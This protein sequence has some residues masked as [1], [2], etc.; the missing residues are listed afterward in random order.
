MASIYPQS[1]GDWV[2]F[3][4]VAG[5][6]GAWL[7]TAVS[8]ALVARSARREAEWRRLH[9]LTDIVHHG[10]QYGHWRQIL[11]ARELSRLQTLK[12]DV[13]WLAGTAADY[14]EANNS[15]GAT[16]EFVAEL[17]ATSGGKSS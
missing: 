2:A 3:L 5:G 8:Q 14:Y 15:N 16:E 10:G 11:A 1:F 6:A 7:W 13:R 9:E 12:L 17:R 4:T